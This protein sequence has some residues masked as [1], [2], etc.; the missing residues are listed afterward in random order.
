M[1][2]YALVIGIPEYQSFASLPNTTADAEAIAQL[3]E[4]QGHFQEVKR[5]PERW[6]TAKNGYEVAPQGLTGKTL[7]DTLKTFL[8]EQAVQSDAVIYFT[9]HG[10]TISDNLGQQSGYL[11]TTDCC[12]DWEGDRAVGQRYGI[13]LDSLNALIQQANLSSL[14]MLLD[15]CHSG[16][17]IEQSIISQSLTILAQKDYYLITSSRQFESSWSGEKHS[18]FTEALIGS[19]LSSNA[20]S[21]GYVT[22][23]RVFD[24]IQRQLRNSGQEPVR[25]GWGR[26]IGLIHY[27]PSQSREQITPLNPQ[28]PY[29]GLKAFEGK[30]SAYFYGRE[31]AIYA[32]LERLQKGRFLSV[33]GASGCGKSSLVKAGLIPKLQDDPLPNSQQWAIAQFTPGDRPLHRLLDTLAPLHNQNQP[34]LLFIDQFEEIF[35]QCKDESNRRDF[36]RLIAEEATTTERQ[37]RVIVAVRGDFLDRCAEYNEIATLINRTQPTTY[38]VEPLSLSELEAAIV[39]PAQ[40]HGVKIEPGLAAQM[41]E[42][43]AHQPG[44]LPLLQYALRELWRVCIAEADSTHPYLTWAGYEQIGEV[45]GALEKRA[46]LIYNSFGQECDRDLLRRL[47]LELVELGD[48]DT[49]VRRR[50]SQKSLSAIA[51]SPEQLQTLL[52]RLSQERLIV[53]TTEK[54]GENTFENYVEVTHEALLSRWE[55]LK[56]WID[57]NR[58]NIRLKRR[59]E[60]DF[61]AWRDRYQQS[62]EALLTGLWLSDIVTWKEQES[63]RLLPAEHQFIAQSIARRDREFQD[64]LNQERILREEAEARAKAES[65]KAQ[66]AQARVKIQKQKTK[67]AIAAILGIICTS[68]LGLVTQLIHYEKQKTDLSTIVNLIS[69][70]EY[71]L[72]SGDQL[73]ATFASIESLS[74]MINTNQRNRNL[75]KDLYAVIQ[76]IQL[77]SLLDVHHSK[78]INGLSFSPDG[79]YLVSGDYEGN[80]AIWNTITNKFEYPLINSQQKNIYDIEFSSDGNIFASTGNDGLVTIFNFRLGKNKDTLEKY[81]LENHS[82]LTFS[83]SIDSNSRLIAISSLDNTVSIQSLKDE[84]NTNNTEGEIS[85]II[86]S[87]IEN[88]RIP[89]HDVIFNPKSSS[90]IFITSGLY[91]HD[92]I[93]YKYNHQNQKYEKDDDYGDGIPTTTAIAFRNEGD[94]LAYGNFKGEVIICDSNLKCNKTLQVFDDLITD[95]DFS[96]NGAYLAVSSDSGIIKIYETHNIL[97]NDR[98][99][100]LDKMPILLNTGNVAIN[101]I[102]FHPKHENILA[103]S[104]EN[105]IVNIWSITGISIEQNLK[106]LD[107][108]KSKLCARV[109]EKLK[110]AEYDTN[111]AKLNKQKEIINTN[112]QNSTNNILTEN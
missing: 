93:K 102:K 101:R 45:G 28:N 95:I 59:F 31:T 55:L 30:N 74:E 65:E 61:L 70:T 53:I 36:F 1:A 54:T 86:G 67:W 64:K 75:V 107:A 42:D 19:L 69:K 98:Y 5:L 79:K 41:A 97:D 9:G 105:G 62:E 100:K 66:E 78:N 38:F 106:E 85:H 2:K 23:D 80:I 112:C 56:T 34:F 16:F 52:E 49:V 46:N 7:G 8:L 11:A 111:T 21:D 68:G 94:I 29:L 84:N 13:S 39:K 35:T 92:L 63:P 76:K 40:Q 87:P 82:D 88:A 18:V 33:I 37:G 20:G 32:L 10:F 15:C 24:F 4:N 89:I 90:E 96:Y 43:V 14:V 104:N 51:D 57:Q 17:F 3:L 48:G 109:K 6:N 73:E 47:S 27:P 103:S 22:V 58:D 91:N 12:I 60:A 77:I 81:T 72:A 110:F 108:V 26:S 25:F 99:Q 83:I 71:S 44:A 50:Q